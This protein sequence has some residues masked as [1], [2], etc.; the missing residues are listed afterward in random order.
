[1]RNLALIVV[2]L[3]LLGLLAGGCSK[4]KETESPT[5]G[6]LHMV[7]AETVAPVVGREIAEFMRL[8]TKAVITCDTMTSREALVK[9]VNGETK[10][11]VLSRDLNPDEKKSLDAAKFSYSSYAL[12]KIGIAVVVNREN[13][14]EKLTLGQLRGIYTGKITSWEEVGGTGGKITPISLSR[15]SGTAEVFLGALGIETG[16][17]GDL[18]VVAASRDLEAA[19]SADPAAIGFVGMNWLTGKVKAVPL[20]K[21]GSSDFIDIHQASVYQGS[22]PLVET[23]Y[24]LSTAGTYALASGLVAFMT[25]AA[26][27]KIFLDSGLVPVTMPV[28]L[29]Q[30]N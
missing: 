23:A 12:T 19:I 16:L 9:F 24:A 30:I 1:V 11:V 13:T 25:S 2:G 7:S 28:K 17:S 21:E 8:Y 14:V 6:T 18:R 26:G 15:N 4:P 29:I 10:M 22:Y 20:A 3:V 27:Q 5:S